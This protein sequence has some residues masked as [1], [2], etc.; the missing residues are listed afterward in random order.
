[1]YWD[2]SRTRAQAD[3]IMLEAMGVLE[4]PTIKKKFIYSAVKTFGGWA[5]KRN[6]WDREGGLDRVFHDK[7]FHSSVKIKR[8]GIFLR[9]IQQVKSERQN[10]NIDEDLGE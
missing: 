6:Q 9:T 4:V 7:D 10:S 5:W 3:D 1:M 2:Q 8:P